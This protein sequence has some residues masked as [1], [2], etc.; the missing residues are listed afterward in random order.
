[1][2]ALTTNGY[3]PPETELGVPVMIANTEISLPETAEELRKVFIERGGNPG[4]KRFQAGE[5]EV[6]ARAHK[7]V[8]QAKAANPFTSASASIGSAIAL[9]SVYFVRIVFIVGLPVALIAVLFAEGF[10]I[11][12]GF[13]IFVPGGAAIIY[14]V[15]LMIFLLV[16]LFVYEVVHRSSAE[17]GEE[18]FSLRSLARRIRYTMGAGDA[19]VE[20]QKA[21]PSPI[22]KVQWAMQAVS[23]SIIFFGILGRLKT[24]LDEPN[25]K[26]LTWPATIGKL[27]TESSLETMLGLVGNIL[28]AMTLLS[29]AHVII[30]LIHRFYVLSTGGLDIASESALGFLAVVN[31]EVVIE[32]EMSQF[33]TDQIYLLEAHRQKS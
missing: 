31:E 3:H 10:A 18:V 9:L 30:Y 14:G 1:M 12:E 11:T 26:G 28:L 23:R 17:T 7:K 4:W 32:R 29:S 15:A 8:E 6:L 20:Q 2:E 24:I 22:Q 25:M 27:L 19:W 16:I 33:L 5:R 13:S 21:A